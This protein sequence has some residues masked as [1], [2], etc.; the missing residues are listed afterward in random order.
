M[1]HWRER[2]P[3]EWC[4]AVS[5]AVLLAIS[6]R[7]P[8]IPFSELFATWSR[9]I[10][11]PL[12]GWSLVAPYDEALAA[13]LPLLGAGFLSLP[14]LTFCSL[15]LHVSRSLVWVVRTAVALMFLLA[16][17]A[18]VDAVT[19]LGAWYVFS[20]I[21]VGCAIGVLFLAFGV[22]LHMKHLLSSRIRL[23]A[24][25]LVVAGACMATFVLLPAGLLMLCAA[26]ILL[27]IILASRQSEGFKQAS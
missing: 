12:L 11:E 24:V 7:V 9:W 27:V 22:Q 8:S 2:F 23:L 10:G 5:G 17:M 20:Q 15:T 25:I 1:K 13:L 3:Y 18:T 6:P 26:Y 21:A 19:D 14:L 4:I 16:G